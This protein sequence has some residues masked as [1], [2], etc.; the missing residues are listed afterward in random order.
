MKL[1]YLVRKTFFWPDLLLIE[2]GLHLRV[3]LYARPIWP[4]ALCFT[5]EMWLFTDYICETGPPAPQGPTFSPCVC[6]CVCERIAGLVLLPC[7]NDR[8]FLKHKPRR[9]GVCVCNRS[10]NEASRLHF[11]HWWFRNVRK[12]LFFACVS[13][14]DGT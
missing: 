10:L 4:C 3:L 13:C 1:V 5:K 6:V 2:L 11:V 9:M 12:S 7:S 8:G 14:S